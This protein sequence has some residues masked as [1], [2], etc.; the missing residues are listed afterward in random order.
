[1]NK[2]QKKYI[3]MFESFNDFGALLRQK[4]RYKALENIETNDVFKFVKCLNECGFNPRKDYYKNII[5]IIEQ[6][7]LNEL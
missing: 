6:Y 3:S 7:K 1:M 5:E 2:G 4:K